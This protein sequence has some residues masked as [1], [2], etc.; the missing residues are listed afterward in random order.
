MPKERGIAQH[1][2]QGA[3]GEVAVGEQAQVDDRMAVGEFPDDEEARA[4]AAISA[5]P[6]MKF[7]SNQ[8]RSLP[9]SRTIC[10]APTPITR[11]I[12]PT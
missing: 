4:I 12:R 8:S 3:G 5:P 2:R 7:D 11:A 10:R 9:L 1:Q 6:T